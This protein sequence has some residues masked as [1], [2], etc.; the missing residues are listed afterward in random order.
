[1]ADVAAG[2]RPGSFDLVTAN[3]PWVPDLGIAIGEQGRFSRGG[4][5]GFELPRRFLVEAAGLLAPGGVAVVLG[6]DVT[7]RDGSRPCWPWS[8]GLV[9]LGFE[10]AV[11]STEQDQIWPDFEPRMLERFPTMAAARH[12]AVLVARPAS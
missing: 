1:M 8:R 6:L 5:T 12:V 10:V 9:R 11:E 4:S 3:P 2:L 7:W